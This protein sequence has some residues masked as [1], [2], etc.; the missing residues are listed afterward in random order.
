MQP[1]IEPCVEPCVEPNA[2]SFPISKILNTVP[3]TPNSMVSYVSQSDKSIQVLSILMV[4]KYLKFECKVLFILLFLMCFHAIA[5]FF[6]ML[7]S[8]DW[9]AGL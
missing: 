9:N 2:L 1:G 5:F 6:I 3:I 7:L 8:H 4:S